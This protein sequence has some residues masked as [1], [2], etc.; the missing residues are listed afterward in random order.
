MSSELVKKGNRTILY[1]QGE[2]FIALAGEVHNSDS[3]SP[4]YMEGIYKIADDLGMNTL[5]MPVTWE[6][7][8]PRE[9][10]FDFSVPQKLILQARKWNKKIVFLWFGSWKNAEMM[11]APEWVKKDLTR[12]TRAQIEK[13]KNKAGRPISKNM[14]YKVPYTT[15]SYLCEE[16]MK[17]D[18]KAFARLMQF[19]REMDEADN[20]VIAVQVENET[21]LLGAAREVSD[22]ADELFESAVPAE[23]AAYMRAH[24]ETMVPD[25]KQ[26]VEG[27]SPAG[28][29][30]EVFG[31]C[32]EEIFSAYHVAS[33]VEYV[34]KAGKEVYPLPLLANCWLDK[35]QEPGMYP[36]GGPV[37]RVHEVW[38]CCAPSID[39]YCPDIY[40][41]NFLEICDEYTRRG[42]PLVIPESATHAYA[43]PRMVY[44]VGHHQAVCYSPFGFDDIGKPF[45]AI[46]GYLFGMD[47]ADPALKTPQNFEEYAAASRNL[48]QLMP[49]IKAALGTGRMDACV[50]EQG[51]M[52]A[53]MLENVMVVGTFQSPMQTR[54]DGYLLAVETGE[55]ELYVMGNACGMSLQSKDPSKP[56]LDL[57]IQE[58]GCFDEKGTWVPGRRLNGDEAASPAFDKPGI[59]RIRYFCYE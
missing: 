30:K 47:V 22:Q 58:E 2:P 26:A 25:V 4:A 53:M 35:G 31:S 3:S 41:P 40:V 9:D 55:D 33:F 51:Q 5:L 1:V 24:T 13:G 52:K 19:I 59:R 16:A 23:F 28:T 32:A 46:Q 17:A 34:A 50:G 38:S 15:I 18:R 11:Y 7:V 10:V 37:S 45:T 36:S 14:P 54:S 43:A 49:F 12:F 57:L 39:A 21:G 42:M 29:W 48:T 6:M 27:G 8:E 56:N 44:T 20:T